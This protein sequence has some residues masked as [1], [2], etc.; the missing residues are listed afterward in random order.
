MVQLSLL[1]EA[2]AIDLEG[3]L[4]RLSARARVRGVAVAPIASAERATGTHFRNW[5]GRPLSR[6]EM[7]RAQAYFEAVVRRTIMMSNDDESRALYRRLVAASIEADLVAGGWDRAR[8]AEEARRTV[9]EI[10]EGAVA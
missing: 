10:A 1:S 9:G 2:C 4:A 8:A 7:A 6:A 5:S 3:H